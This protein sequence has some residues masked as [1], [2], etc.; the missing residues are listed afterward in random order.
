MVLR[1]KKDVDVYY[2]S[3]FVVFCLFMA[4]VGQ[5]LLIV[6]GPRSHPDTS[7]SVGLLWTSDHPRHRDHCLLTHNN[8]KRQTSISQAG[9]K[10]TV[11]ASEWPQTVSLDLASTAI[12]FIFRY[13]VLHSTNRYVDF[14]CHEGRLKT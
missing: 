5:G 13:A 6:E 12:A 4:L 10:P 7:H 9:L 11:P 1:R 14:G 2:V 3:R 8:H